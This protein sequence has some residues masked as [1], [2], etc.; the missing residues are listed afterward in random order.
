MAT[1]TTSK[2]E[3]LACGETVVEVRDLGQHHSAGRDVEPHDASRPAEF[4]DYA[5]RVVT[6]MSSLRMLA[7]LRSS[8]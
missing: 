7:P 8:R 2:I 6:G 4:R 3:C 1:R 5:R